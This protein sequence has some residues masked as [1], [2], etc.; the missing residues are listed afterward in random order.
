MS[1]IRDAV[2]C[3]A[4]T[5][6]VFLCQNF[7]MQLSFSDVS[8]S[9]YPQRA[10]LYY[11]KSSSGYPIEQPIST[12]LP[13]LEVCGRVGAIPPEKEQQFI[14]KFTRECPNRI[15]FDDPIFLIEGHDPFGRTGNQLLTF[16]HA[17]EKARKTGR[18]VGVVRD[19]WVLP[20]LTTFFMS[21]QNGDYNGFKEQME[22][23]FCI[24]LLT[25]EELPN[26]TNLVRKDAKDI[27]IYNGDSDEDIDEYVAFQTF[28]IR[29]LLRHYNTGEGVNSQN[30]KTRNMC[31]GLVEMF[32]Q[33][34]QTQLYSV[35]HSRSLERK[36]GLNLLGR[37][38]TKSGCDPTAAL[39]MEP[40]YIKAILEPL[41]M[42][43]YPIVLITDGQDSSV[44]GRLLA[45]KDIAPMLRLVPNRA[46]WVGGDITL[47]I[48]S[49]VFIGNPAS[50]LSGFIAKSRLAL[51]LENTHM[52]RAKNK[53]GEWVS[54]CDITCIFS[55]RVMKSMA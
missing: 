28:H 12:Q 1:K 39:H 42:L 24:K 27:F 44:A 47:A 55:R 13:P 51:G 35:I 32:G 25:R 26:Y 30:K 3:I 49:N 54:V 21:I 11:E 52:F 5:T 10:Q 53:K 8:T 17:L 36:S 16:L 38:S 33:D 20:V 23:I 4:V 48:M 37:I 43:N 29:N 9:E 18:F 31:I 45:D 34:R 22:K 40:D 15:A 50:T 7:F 6:L 46:R 41:G 19:G 14:D 2:G